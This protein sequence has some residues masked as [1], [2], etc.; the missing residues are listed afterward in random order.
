MEPSRPEIAALLARMIRWSEQ[1]ER[2]ILKTLHHEREH[3]DPIRS[4][5]V[6]GRRADPG[7]GLPL[8]RRDSDPPTHINGLPRDVLDSWSKSISPLARRPMEAE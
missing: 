6:D 8:Q 1:I 4:T 3:A 2:D 5:Q 7:D